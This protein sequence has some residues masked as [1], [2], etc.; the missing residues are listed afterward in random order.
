MAVQMRSVADKYLKFQFS[1]KPITSVVQCVKS[2]LD[3][4]CIS[5]LY[6][7][8]SSALEHF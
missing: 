5:V 1:R 7:H 4:L 2:S 8:S 6:L 3:N